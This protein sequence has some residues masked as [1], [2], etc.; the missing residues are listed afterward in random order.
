V[1]DKNEGVQWLIININNLN[2]IIFL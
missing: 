1:Q 2:I